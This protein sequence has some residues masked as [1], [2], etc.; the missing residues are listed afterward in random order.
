MPH[1]GVCIHWTDRFTKTSFDRQR[2]D[3]GSSILIVVIYLF[4]KHSKRCPKC[5]I[6]S[7]ASLIFRFFPLSF[8][9]ID[10]FSHE[11]NSHGVIK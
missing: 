2:T 3:R 11:N 5:G 9:G 4:L 8:V 1:G 6:R 7:P 10:I